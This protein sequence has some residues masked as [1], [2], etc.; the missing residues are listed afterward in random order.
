[1]IRAR[2]FGRQF[3]H[4]VTL[5][6]LRPIALLVFVGTIVGCASKQ[7]ETPLQRAEAAKGLFERTAKAF[8]IPSAE[9]QGTEREKLQEQASDGYVQL[10]RRY[11]EQEYWAAQAL[12]SLGNIRAAQNKVDAAIKNYAAVNERYPQQRWEVLMSW[13]SGADLLW[14]AGRKDEA[15]AFY[16]KIV[17]RYDLPEI[18]QLEQTIVRGSKMR[19]ASADLPAEK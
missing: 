14:E 3:G 9:A 6:V 11:P 19:L 2:N 7:A 1:M 15:K 16:Q 12:R 17:A 5:S 10:L 13:K 8:H 18:P 4:F